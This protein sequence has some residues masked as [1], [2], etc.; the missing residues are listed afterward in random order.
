MKHSAT[1]LGV[2][3]GLVLS[4]SELLAQW[5]PIA[6]GLEYREF[7]LAGPGRVFV[8][9]A[10]RRVDTWTIDTMKGQGELKGGRETVPG[11][12][13]RYNNSITFDGYR[14]DVKVAI[15][16]DYF[17]G[18]TGV[19]FEGQIMAGWFAKRFGEY[20]GGSGFVWGSDR[21][22]FLGGNVQNGPAL[23]RVVFAD[24]ATMKLSQLNEPRAA[25]AL[26]LYTSHFA[27]DTGTKADGTEVL[28]RMSRPLGLLA[29]APG[30]IVKVRDNAGSSP[31]PFNHVVLS[32]HGKA[33]VELLRHARVGQG[34]HFDLDLK[35]HGNAGIGLTPHD[36]H[37]A[38]ASIGG[39]KCVL[40]DGK[41]PRDW[42]AKAK[43]YAEKGQVHGSVVKD[44]RTAIAFNERYIYFLVIDGRSKQS[45]GMT[46][47]EAGFFCRDELQATEA[48]LQ[49]GGGSSTLWV[50][51]K[52]KNIPSGK[53]KDEKAGVLR[54]VANGY[55]IAEVLPPK[56]STEFR[57]GQQVRLKGE[58]RLGPGS[59]FGSAA[60]VAD[61]AT[62]TILP[63]A[64]NGIFAKGAYWWFC[65][66]GDADGWASLDQLVPAH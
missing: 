44:P 53:G 23:Q 12:A 39:P 25:D 16:G 17:N 66:F 19:P 58:L 31:L 13:V 50:D 32:A 51:G 37:N 48:M 21:R 4:A 55:F 5:S 52:V 20:A 7:N 10:D 40:V 15:N 62:G 11:M 41:V 65:R 3:L 56:K 61:N 49:D 26:A 34:V 43:K 22:A 64:L 38:Y 18:N 35:D 36:W 30:K 28:V 9:R 45:I 24:G 59:T 54:A 27:A 46:F 14:Y 60:K 47:T 29:K 63:E 2:A 6:P 8:A 1:C 57:D 42:E 33:A